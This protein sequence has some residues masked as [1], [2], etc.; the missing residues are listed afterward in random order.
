MSGTASTKDTRYNTWLAKHS[1]KQI[2]LCGACGAEISA[3]ELLCVDCRGALNKL[4]QIL[5]S[6][7]DEGEEARRTR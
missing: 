2:N 4:S 5:T 1:R 3:T 7:E 6:P